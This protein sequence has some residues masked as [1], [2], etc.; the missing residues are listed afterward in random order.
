M[1]L[2]I[3]SSSTSRSR[4]MGNVDPASGFVKVSGVNG[5]GCR[6]LD[7]VGFGG[8]TIAKT[9]DEHTERGA[10]RRVGGGRRATGRKVER[11]GS[12]PPSLRSTSGWEGADAE[13]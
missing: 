2:R 5:L 6:G 11:H 7:G 4:V 1:L 12:S 3:A 10:D 9:H 8:D 13:A